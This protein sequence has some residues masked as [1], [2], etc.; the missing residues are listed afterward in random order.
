MEKSLGD[1]LCPSRGTGNKNGKRSKNGKSSRAGKAGNFTQSSKGN[2]KVPKIELPAQTQL[3]L[4]AI[5]SKASKGQ[6]T[7]PVTQMG[8][9]VFKMQSPA[10]REAAEMCVLLP[11]MSLL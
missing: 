9:Q 8:M 2:N 10:I 5:P 4:P 11:V 6:P 1:V 7:P 3:A